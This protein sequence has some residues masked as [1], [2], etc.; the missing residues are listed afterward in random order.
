V[1]GC[2]VLIRWNHPARGLVMP[3]EFI[4]FAEQIGFIQHIDAWVMRN[5]FEAARTVGALH[6]GFRLYFNLSGRQVGDP[7][8]VRNLGL[9]ALLAPR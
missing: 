6:P 1:T 9:S 4:P 2:E 3:S 8:T 7:R 5:A